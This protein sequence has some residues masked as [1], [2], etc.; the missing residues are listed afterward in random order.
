MGDLTFHKL[1]G[2]GDNDSIFFNLST[3]IL[4]NTINTEITESELR[5]RD[6][7]NHED[8]NMG[9]EVYQSNASSFQKC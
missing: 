8:M 7:D 6:K 4:G 3:H 2:D 1:F 9:F 5:E